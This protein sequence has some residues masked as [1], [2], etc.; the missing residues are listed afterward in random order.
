M[1]GRILE[2]RD[3]GEKGLTVSDYLNTFGEVSQF[4]MFHELINAVGLW[5]TYPL[6][7]EKQEFIRYWERNLQ[8]N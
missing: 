1:G 2:K 6:G 7:I 8:N 4:E 5:M 3:I